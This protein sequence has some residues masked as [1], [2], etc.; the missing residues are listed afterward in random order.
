MY[1]YKRSLFSLSFHRRLFKMKEDSPGNWSREALSFCDASVCMNGQQS[2]AERFI[3][4]FGQD[5][6]GKLIK[7]YSPARDIYFMVD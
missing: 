7:F 5:R 3:L 4:S 2:F 6:E 1:R